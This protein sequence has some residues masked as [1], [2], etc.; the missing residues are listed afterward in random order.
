MIDDPWETLGV[1]QNASEEEIRAAYLRLVKEYP[2]ER[3]P[4]RFAQI[5]DAYAA[6]KSPEELLRRQL[7]QL[8]THDSLA[9]LQADVR[10]ELR[11]RRLSVDALIALVEV[12]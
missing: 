8:E 4:E 5:R 3:A 9:Q 10:A 1:A 7:F 2:P 6:L 11:R 12:K